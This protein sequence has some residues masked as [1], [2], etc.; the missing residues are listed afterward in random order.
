M[1]NNSSPC[2]FNMLHR[3]AGEYDFKIATHVL[4]FSLLKTVSH[5]G[6]EKNTEEY[7]SI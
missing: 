2:G 1:L 3:K 6:T 5:G 7:K 4:L